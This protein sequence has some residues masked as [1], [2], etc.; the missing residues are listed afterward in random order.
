M[1]ASDMSAVSTAAERALRDLIQANMHRID[2]FERW[3]FQAPVDLAAA[4]LAAG[5]S[6]QTET[7]ES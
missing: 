6:K 7:K 1:G 2:G 5:Y 3:T 4:L